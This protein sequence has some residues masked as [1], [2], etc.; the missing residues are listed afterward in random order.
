MS[1]EIKFRA[2][3]KKNHKMLAFDEIDVY[4]GDYGTTLEGAFKIVTKQSP[5]CELMQYT[6]LKDKNG[7]EIYEGDITKWHYGGNWEVVWSDGHSNI[8][9]PDDEWGNQVG[10]IIQS[11]EKDDMGYPK[12]EPLASD[13]IYEVIGNKYENPELLK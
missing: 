2:W 8:G 3:D 1:K 9:E 4:I 7:K 13:R 12:T 6:G 11:Q 10:F 5:K